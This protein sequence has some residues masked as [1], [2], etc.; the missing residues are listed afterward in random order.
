MGWF[1]SGKTPQLR[2]GSTGKAFVDGGPGGFRARFL[3]ACH[4]HKTT[5]ANLSDK[6]KDLLHTIIVTRVRKKLTGSKISSMDRKLM[7]HDA[8]RAF[9]EGRISK[10]DLQDFSRMINTLKK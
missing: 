6:D 3:R 9:K 5:L 10:E 2:V 1:G 8:Q 4:E 7:R